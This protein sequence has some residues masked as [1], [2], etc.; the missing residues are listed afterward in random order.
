M[1]HKSSILRALTGA[2]LAFGITAVAP[3]HAKVT[4]GDA[5]AYV[6]K[7]TAF[8]E[9]VIGPAPVASV[10]GNGTDSEFIGSIKLSDSWSIWRQTS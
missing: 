7:A 8:D 9:P 3:A 6:I 10:T 1:K 4:E 2:I 5:S